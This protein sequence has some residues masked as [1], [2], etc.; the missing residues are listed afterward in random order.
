MERE[1]TIKDLEFYPIPE[2]WIENGEMGPK[3]WLN[4]DILTGLWLEVGE[5]LEWEGTES[6]RNS[7]GLDKREV[8]DF[9]YDFYEYRKELA[10][11]EMYFSDDADFDIDSATA[12][13]NASEMLEDYYQY[14]EWK[15]KP[16]PFTKICSDSYYM[17]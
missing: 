11:E 15:G 5:E 1:I 3:G 16:C 14:I 4:L 6:F 2:N 8:Q 7:Y 9:F 17:N 12:D 13:Y 10:F